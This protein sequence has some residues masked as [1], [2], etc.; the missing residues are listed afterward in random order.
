M[1]DSA[2]PPTATIARDREPVAQPAVGSDRA[3]TGGWRT[4]LLAGGAY[5]LLSL[6]VWSH[7]WLGHPATATTCGCGDNSLFTWFI[8]WPAYAI[9]HGLNP[10]YST[11]MFY[12]SGVN[13]LSNTGVVGIG[14]LLAPVTWLF[15]PIATLNLALTLSP[16]LSA[17]AMFVLLRRWVSWTPAAFIGGLF[18][19][20]SP[21]VLVSLTN[22][23]LM[24]GMAAIP[25]L[26]VLCLDELLFRQ[27]RSPVATG[28]L[29]GLLVVVQ[30]FIGTEVLAIMAI[31]AAIGLVLVFLYGAK[32]RGTWRRQGRHAAVGLGA[33]A[34]TAVV[35]LAY[36]V[37]FAL[38]GPAH[39]SGPIW[40]KG[41]SPLFPYGIGFSGATIKEFVVPVGS[42]EPNWARITQVIGAYQG[43]SRSDHYFGVGV[44]A[45]LLAGLV[46]WRRDRR[47][48]LFSAITAISVLLSLG[49][50][51]DVFLPWQVAVNLPLLQNIFAE[52]FVSLTYIAVAI[53][54]GLI[55][56]HAY[57][58]TNRRGETPPVGPGVR[59]AGHRRAGRRRWRGAAAGA[60][61]AA[62]AL[63]PT[64]AYVAASIPVTVRPVNLPPWFRSVAPH[65]AAH[66]VL[67]VLPL[68]FVRESALTWQAVD[69]MRY[70]EVG[71]G[72]PGSILPRAGKEAKGLA[73][74][75]GA[76]F[77]FTT[78]TIKAGD[79]R[80]VRRA[81]DEWGVTMVVIPDQRDLLGYQQ[82]GSMPFAVALITAATGRRPVHRGDAWTWRAL[83]HAGDSTIPSTGTFSRCTTREKSNSVAAIETMNSCVLGDARTVG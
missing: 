50:R 23:H 72:G 62:V 66:Q 49:A 15:G 46:A 58:A 80:A 81:L 64:A 1:A 53:L 33:G 82:V 54:L 75:Y 35:L 60:I 43:P 78:P 8:E 29:L 27:R 36:P 56:D 13:L 31:G 59:R 39:L 18:Y 6:I 76:S 11:A 67:L 30:F 83:N 37:W 9:S 42:V 65:L 4:L 34:V 71:G 47:L 28:I 10:L 17:L 32:Q 63:V 44:V 5:L 20:F 52:R 22:A 73:V 3:P 70:A 14:V 45:V 57:R 55:I 7:V 61:V 74:L 24:L 16:V 69:G 38:A 79:V 2:S 77:S 25:P 19:G 40:P 51:K 26:V 41:V 12:P 21:F 48:W 68:P